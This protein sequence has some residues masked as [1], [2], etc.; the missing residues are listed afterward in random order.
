M[1]KG[2]AGTIPAPCHPEKRHWAKGLCRQCWNKQYNKKG[3]TKTFALGGIELPKGF[4][5]YIWLRE[6][7]TPYYVGKGKGIRGFSIRSHRIRP[8]T[9][10]CRIVVQE[11]ETEDDALFAEMFLI[12]VYGREDLATGI[13]LNLTDGGEKP[14]SPLGKKRT[15]EEIKK[16]A[17]SRRGSWH[18]TEETKKRMSEQRKGRAAWNKGMK[19]VY[20]NGPMSEESK[21]HL[22]DVNL[23]KRVSEE[24]KLKI[25]KTLKEKGLRPPNWAI[26]KAHFVRWGYVRE[27]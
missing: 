10:L 7:G 5:T 24:T 27:S 16:S 23:G 4:Y 18:H 19:G 11:F 13:L 25:S 26:E 22:R 20:K 21:R 8:P 14:P 12:S 9:E 2:I 15:P 17:D 6:D 3:P 1:P